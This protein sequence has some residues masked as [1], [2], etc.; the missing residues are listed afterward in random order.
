ME[1]LASRHVPGCLSTTGPKTAKTAPRLPPGQLGKRYRT[2]ALYH[3]R[4]WAG[5]S[6]SRSG[7]SKDP[8][9]LLPLGAP[10][11]C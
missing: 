7:A 10:S 8:W 2:R 3:L 4:N 9:L 6:R 5:P 1:D 11:G